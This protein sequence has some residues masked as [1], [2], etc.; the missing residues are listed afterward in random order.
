MDRLTQLCCF[1]TVHKIKTHQKRRKKNEREKKTIRNLNCTKY[2]KFISPFAMS[3]FFA[4]I[5]RI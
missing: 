1:S 4:S 3:H 5:V 2:E